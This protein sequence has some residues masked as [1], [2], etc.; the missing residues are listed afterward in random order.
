MVTQGVG[1]PAGQ[2]EGAGPRASHSCWLLEAKGHAA[3]GIFVHVGL[4]YLEDTLRGNKGEMRTVQ[5]HQNAQTGI[6]VSLWPPH[7]T[8]FLSVERLPCLPYGGV[9]D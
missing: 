5:E 8:P 4:H 3:L 2:Q 6:S 7:P 9:G 1:V